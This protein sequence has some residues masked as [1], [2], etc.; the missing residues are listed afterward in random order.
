MLANPCGTTGNASMGLE[1]YTGA[2]ATRTCGFA[3]LRPT[4]PGGTQ[5]LTLSIHSIGRWQ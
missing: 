4:V 2:S 1:Y 3:P 5:V